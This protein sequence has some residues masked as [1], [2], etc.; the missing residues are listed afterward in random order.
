MDFEIIQLR[1]AAGEISL[2]IILLKDQI[3]DMRVEIESLRRL[4]LADCEQRAVAGEIGQTAT[5]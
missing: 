4:V 5:P 1:R 3:E 2:Q